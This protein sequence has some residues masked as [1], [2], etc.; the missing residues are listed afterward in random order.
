VYSEVGKGTLF[1]LYFPSAEQEVKP[2]AEQQE[3]PLVARG[4]RILYVDDD[5]ALVLLAERTLT[6]L[7]YAVR[8]EC[9]SRAALERFRA[10][11]SEFDAVVTDLSMPGMPGFRLAREL[12]SIRPDLPVIV[13]SGYV[14]AADQEMAKTVGVRALILKPNTIDELGGALDTLFKRVQNL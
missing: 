3:T 8:G 14:T 11:P 6:R 4:Q 9:D 2:L 12:L 10:G 1:N 13:T 7:G 5:E